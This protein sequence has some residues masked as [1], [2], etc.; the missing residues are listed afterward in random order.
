MSNL[1]IRSIAVFC[2]AKNEIDEEYR[3]VARQ[4]AQLLAENNV[5]LVYGGTSAGLLGEVS[6]N[7]RSA[8]GKV[9]GVYP[10]GLN[11]REPINKDVDFSYIVDTLYQR[12]ELM[13]DKSDAFIILP[14]G[15]GTLDEMFEVITLK[16]LAAHNKPIIFINHNGYWNI[17]N[18]LIKHIVEHK[19]AAASVFDTYRFVSS[20]KEAFEKLGF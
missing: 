17:V 16:I 9:L 3:V 8:G 5:M 15:L 12:K 20:P 7:V 14:G 11:A 18:D 6:K 2:G 13:I 19:F 4:T 1:K 10:K